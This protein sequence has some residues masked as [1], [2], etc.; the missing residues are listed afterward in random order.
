MKQ[1]C[2]WCYKEKCWHMKFKNF[3]KKLLFLIF[4]CVA[5]NANSQITLKFLP[6]VP[7]EHVDYIILK[8]DSIIRVNVCD[9]IYE[10]EEYVPK[11]KLWNYEY[12]ANRLVADMQSDKKTIAI[13][14]FHLY[15]KVIK[16]YLDGI[17]L[18][19]TSVVTNTNVYYIR[20]MLKIIMHELGHIYKLEHCNSKF[21][22]MEAGGVQ[23]QLFLYDN[24]D[25]FCDKCKNK[26]KK[27]GMLP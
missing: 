24:E 23:N 22:F 12:E 11:T 17:T 3:I 20:R 26:L 10:V 7:M 16:G 6:G 27:I 1:L 25:S 14:Y 9:S 21:C 4:T 2:S 5:I 13:T 18:N 8:V 15:D 19:K